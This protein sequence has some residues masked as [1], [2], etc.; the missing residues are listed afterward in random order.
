[1]RLRRACCASSKKVI[2]ADPIGVLADAAF[3]TP[4]SNLT[5][6]TAWIGVAAYTFQ[7]YF[8]FSGYSDM[9]IGL[10]RMFGLPIGVPMARPSPPRRS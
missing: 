5:A 3:A 8:D 7:I 4:H 10:A 6:L 9:A 2:I 1:M